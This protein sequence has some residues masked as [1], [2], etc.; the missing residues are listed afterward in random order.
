LRAA[1]RSRS[2]TGVRDLRST[3][4]EYSPAARRAQTLARRSSP[5]LRVGGAGCPRRDATAQTAGYAVNGA[6]RSFV[7]DRDIEK[8][9]LPRV[10]RIATA[11]E[12]NSTRLTSFKST[13][14]D[15][16]PDNVGPWPAR[17]SN[18]SAVQLRAPDGGA[19]LQATANRQLQWPVSRPGS[20]LMARYRDTSA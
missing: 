4:A 13:R 17:R 16:P 6:P 5:L 15:K 8:S 14:F 9:F 7:D 11:P 19:Q 3:A 2:S 20:Q 12:A 10:I 18:V 1:T